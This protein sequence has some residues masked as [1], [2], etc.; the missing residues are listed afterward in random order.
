MKCLFQISYQNVICI[1]HLFQQCAV[2]ISQHK[3]PPKSLIIF[4]I[5]TFELA[6]GNEQQQR[7]FSLCS[8]FNQ[9]TKTNLRTRNV[10]VL[11]ERKNCVVEYVRL[12]TL[13]VPPRN[14]TGTNVCHSS[15]CAHLS[16][17]LKC[18][19]SSSTTV[20]TFTNYCLKLN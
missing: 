2:S 15:P 12:A 16:L 17:H 13:A 6:S 19:Q 9:R 11:L 7:I 10:K 14:S 20:Q 5:E 4:R 3:V 8:L 1:S 18:Q